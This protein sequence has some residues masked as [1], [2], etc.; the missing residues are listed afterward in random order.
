MKHKTTKSTGLPFVLIRKQF[1][2]K[3]SFIITINKSQGQT[4]PNV[5][6]YFP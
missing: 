1:P 5:G 3:L 6:I 2:V 4:I